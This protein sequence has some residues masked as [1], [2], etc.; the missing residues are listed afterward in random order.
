M[1]KLGELLGRIFVT[2]LAAMRPVRTP[3][4]RE[5]DTDRALARIKKNNDREWMKL[6]RGHGHRGRSKQGKR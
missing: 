1:T 5:M 6:H 3:T 2:L 4:T